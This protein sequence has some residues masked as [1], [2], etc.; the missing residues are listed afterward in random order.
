MVQRLG[1][2]LLIGI[3][4]LSLPFKKVR[5]MFS[6]VLHGAFVGRGGNG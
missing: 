2:L 6:N 3:L 5:G 4:R 1:S